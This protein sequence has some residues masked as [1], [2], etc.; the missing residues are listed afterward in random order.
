MNLM[1][2]FSFLRAEHSVKLHVCFFQMD[3]EVISFEIKRGMKA[4]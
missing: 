2:D 1:L 3:S 4:H